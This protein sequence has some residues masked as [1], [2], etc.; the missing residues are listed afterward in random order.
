MKKGHN[1]AK[2]IKIQLA[3]TMMRGKSPPLKKS[4]KSHKCKFKNGNSAF[5]IFRRDIFSQTVGS[6]LNDV[7]SI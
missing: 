7:V 1:S 6:S 5:N 2:K 3:I 4:F